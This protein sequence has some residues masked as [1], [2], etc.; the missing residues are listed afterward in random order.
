MHVVGSLIQL[1]DRGIFLFHVFNRNGIML[2]T[3]QPSDLHSATQV[4][5]YWDSSILPWVE[6]NRT[7]NMEHWVLGPRPADCSSWLHLHTK[8]VSPA[9]PAKH[10]VGVAVP[11]HTVGWCLCMGNALQQRLQKNTNLIFTGV[12][13]KWW[14]LGLVYKSD[15]EWISVLLYACKAPEVSMG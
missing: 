15:A 14:L 1:P 5:S 11:W 9:L 4:D 3:R 7:G 13:P 10:R 6:E 2:L 12:N 8:A